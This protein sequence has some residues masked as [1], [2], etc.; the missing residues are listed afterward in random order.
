M[1]I[2]NYPSI[3]TSAEVYAALQECAQQLMEGRQ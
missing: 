3:L 1:R 2:Y